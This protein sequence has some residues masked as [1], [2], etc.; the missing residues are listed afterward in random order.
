[1][2]DKGNSLQQ[3]WEPAGGL[4]AGD[5]IMIG[6]SACEIIAEY[7]EDGQRV[8]HRHVCNRDHCNYRWADQT[9]CAQCP[10]CGSSATSEKI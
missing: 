3:G 4:R 1:M 6:G 8:D 10:L 5:V 7:P 9:E 2:D